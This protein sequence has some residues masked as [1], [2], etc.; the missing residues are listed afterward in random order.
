MANLTIENDGV[1]ANFACKDDKANHAYIHNDAKG[2]FDY[3][4]D[5]FDVLADITNLDAANFFEDHN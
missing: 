5:D 3:K 1:E 4:D 2:N